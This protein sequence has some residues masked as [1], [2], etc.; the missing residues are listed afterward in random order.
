MKKKRINKIDYYLFIYLLFYFFQI[1]KA[2]CYGGCKIVDKK[3]T[4]NSDYLETCDATCFSDLTDNHCYNVTLGPTDYYIFGAS[5]SIGT[6]YKCW[7]N[8]LVFNTRQ[9]VSNCIVGPIKFYE[10]DGVC[11]TKEDCEKGNRDCY[12]ASNGYNY[13]ECKYLYSKIPYMLETKYL[14]HCYDQGELCGPEHTQY[15][16]DTRECGICGT[17]KVKKYETR[18]KSTNILRC[19]TKCKEGEFKHNGYCLDACPATLF[20]YNDPIEGYICVNSCSSYLNGYI[21]GNKCVPICTDYIYDNRTCKSTCDRPF[22]Y[23]EETKYDTTISKSKWKVI[24]VDSYHPNSPG[25]NAIDENPIT[26][27]HTFFDHDNKIYS[28]VPHTIIVDMGE[29]YNVKA[30][31]YLTRQ[32]GSYTE[33]MVKTYDFYLSSD[34][35]IW[36]KCISDGKFVETRSEQMATISPSRVARYFKFEAKQEIKDRA[37]TTAGEL[38]IQADPLNIHYCTKSCGTNKYIEN[39]SCKSSCTSLRYISTNN[40][41]INICVPS[42][43]CYLKSDDGNTNKYC[44]Y[45]CKESGYPYYIGTTCYKSCPSGTPYHVEGKFECIKNCPPNYYLS[46]N[47]CYCGGLYAYTTSGNNRDKICYADELACQKEGY[48]YRK[49]N[50]CLKQCAP[51]YELE[52]NNTASNFIL[53]RCYNNK[54]EC[55]SSGYFFYNSYMQRCWST[56][57][58]NMWSIELDNEGKPQEDITKST[59]VDKCGKDYPK[60]TEGTKVCKRN[61][62]MVNI[63]C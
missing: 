15:N 60:Y 56:C 13:C 22:L 29:A 38:G 54:E 32:D 37:Y 21:K 20:E 25:K 5:H 58:Y 47:I 45:S 61:V 34:G 6:S 53:K 44:Y 10:M 12:T 16:S 35:I 7:N 14:R 24:Y 3:C 40:G 8:K 46:G 23:N 62:I 50:E 48:I 28:W 17:E 33:G 1:I 41:N 39:E 43:G 55:K 11:Y 59:C 42:S 18:P 4:H 51:N 63:I 36:V 57:P 19:S 27:W 30:F 49:G 31:K 2:D 26:L 52:L 9:C